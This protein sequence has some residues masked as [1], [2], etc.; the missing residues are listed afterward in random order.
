MLEDMRILRDARGTSAFIVYGPDD[1]P[2]GQRISYL[3]AE[4]NGQ[5]FTFGFDPDVPHALTFAMREFERFLELN[6]GKE[7]P[8]A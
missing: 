2:T 7:E 8:D 4:R 5:D 3:Q 6:G 1:K